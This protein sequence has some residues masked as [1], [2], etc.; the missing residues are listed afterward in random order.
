MLC[1]NKKCRTEIDDSFR[2]CPVCGKAQEPQRRR[3]A[4]RGNGS[5]SVY[6]RAD[7]KARPWV[8]VTP[9]EW[10][11]D[12]NRTTHVIGYYAT[13]QEATDALESYRRNPTAKLNMTVREV[14]EEWSAI[15]YQEISKQTQDNYTAAWKKLTALSNIKFRELRTAQ[16]QAQI[17]RI[18]NMS[19][20]TLS[21]VK[22]LLTQ[23]CDY[24]VQNDIVSKNYAA[25]I[26][27]PKK[28]KTRKDC[29]TDLEV[30]Q[31]EKSAGAIPYA[32]V[33]LMMCYTGFRVSEFLSLTIHSYNPQERTLTGG[34]KTDA[35]KDRIV[36]VHPKIQAFLAA[37]MNKGGDTIICKEDG[38]RMTADYFR[39]QCY[40]PAL[41][42][43]G[44]RRLS[45]HAT[46][47]TFATRLSAAGVRTEDI[48]E[49]CGHEDYS[50]TA[51]VY[52]HQN[53]E[54]LRQSI[55]MMA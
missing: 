41:D 49:L 36:P 4:R 1:R 39:R 46:R 28:E 3:S 51:N 38:S 43:I 47:H 25:F 29:F 10:D 44:V 52:V 22:A 27:L 12:G 33:I 6:K 30:K 48:Q 31:I 37:W 34:M 11:E 40:Y 24:A 2:F 17:D 14:Y 26:R 54:E 15:A 18:S 9:A 8:A 42:L 53:V 19:M 45:P 21:K 5:G 13:A 23:I 35:G 55:E 16:M 32:D 20:S 7:L 50:M